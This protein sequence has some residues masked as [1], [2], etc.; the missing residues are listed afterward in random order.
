MRKTAKSELANKLES[1]VEIPLQKPQ[2]IDS[3]FID[4]MLL[5]QEL[6]EKM[7]ETFKDLAEV[8]LKRILRIFTD[9]PDCCTVSIIFD[10]YDIDDSIKSAERQRRGQHNIGTYSIISTRKV[11]NY[12]EFLKSTSNKMA[13]IKFV[14]QYLIDSSHKLPPERMFVIAGGLQDGNSC[15]KVSNSII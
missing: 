1:L 4:G 3:Y 6:N 10:R 9:N 14:T 13:L 12:R 7:F 15:I 5:L 11:P 2:N 8:I